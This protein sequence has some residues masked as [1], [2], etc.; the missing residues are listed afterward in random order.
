MLTLSHRGKPEQESKAGSSERWLFHFSCLPGS[1]FVPHTG[2][3][4]PGTVLPWELC[5]G[6]GGCATPAPLAK[7][8]HLICSP[9]GWEPQAAARDGKISLCWRAGGLCANQL[10]TGSCWAGRVKPSLKV[11]EMPENICLTTKL[12]GECFFLISFSKRCK[13]KALGLC[14]CHHTS[15]PSCPT[16]FLQHRAEPAVRAGLRIYHCC[17][18]WAQ[19]RAVY[20]TDLHVSDPLSLPSLSTPSASNLPVNC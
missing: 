2:A 18:K 10:P 20:V 19:S 17:C 4:S 1:D 16:S 3:C 13:A 8:W 12:R 15:P 6:R 11:R 5:L 7:A 14:F 9:A